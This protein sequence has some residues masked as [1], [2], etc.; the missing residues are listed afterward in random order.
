M[1]TKLILSSSMLFISFLLILQSCKK[2]IKQNTTTGDQDK[3]S[4]APPSN[5]TILST[6]GAAVISVF[7]VRGAH[8]TGYDSGTNCAPSSW[9]CGSTYSNSDFNSSHIGIDI[10]A[11]LNTPVA[12][13]VSGTL[14]YT[15]NNAY[16]GNK[17]TIKTS[18]GWYHFFCHLNSLAPGIVNGATVTAGQIIGYVGSTGTASNGV[19]HLHYSL[20]P[21]DNYNAGI[22]PWS[23]LNAVETSVCSTP[24]T[25]G[26]FED[27]ASGV[28]RFNRAPTYSGSTL[29]VNTTSTAA[30]YVSGTATHLKVT[31]ND[32]TTVST[33]WFVRLLSG[34]GLVANNVS[35]PKTGTL[36]FY[37][38]TNTA[39]V[40]A[41]VRI[42]VDDS[43]GTEQSPPITV[44]N[45]GAWHLYSWNLSSFRGTTV[46]GGNGVID[47]AN[48]TL[49]AIILS[50]PNTSVQWVS[51]I[52]DVGN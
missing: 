21:D 28:G 40:G 52:D 27:F 14:V 26:I 1:K 29:G 31:L 2:E 39:Q 47:A 23:L 4:L 17:V 19:V 38:K 18:T 42:W 12:A 32:N 5:S 6:T 36:Y 24:P 41:T 3:T 30:H 8:N 50:Q 34:D 37:L 45:D 11:A 48:V 33:N 46:T 15:G 16:S 44:I 35:S 13:T 51:Y 20:Y 25:A 10:W 9:N 7:P 43:D 22:N 49:D